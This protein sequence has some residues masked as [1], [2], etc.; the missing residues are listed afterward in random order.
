MNNNN[1]TNNNLS[2]IGSTHI[3]NNKITS[4]FILTT[5]NIL[6]THSSNFTLATS[7]ILQSNS[8][9][10]TNALRYDVNKWIN[11][12]TDELIPNLNVI[13]TYISNSNIGGYIN[14]WTKDSQKLY[15]RINQNGKL[16]IYHD[17][18][19]GR[20]NLNTKWYEVEDILMDYLFNIVIINAGA[21][22][23]GVKFDTIDGQLQTHTAQI[24]TLFDG[25]VLINIELTKHEEL[26]DYLF[27]ELD[28][29]RYTYFNGLPDTTTIVNAM[30]QN[31]QSVSRIN[32]YV[33][34]LISSGV[35][36]GLIGGA[37]G[38]IISNEKE[39]ERL[40]QLYNKI[41]DPK[42][43]I[44][45]LNTTDKNNLINEVNQAFSN[46]AFSYNSNLC[47][48][49]MLNGFINSNMTTAQTIPNI[50]TNSI[51]YN[52]VEISNG[53][54]KK[55]DGGTI[56][57]PIAISAS[58]S[59]SP[60]I[61]YFGNSTG[62]RYILQPST[63]T[64][65]YP[66]SLGIDLNSKS[67]WFS[68]SSNY[69]YDWYIGGSNLLSLNSNNLNFPN[70]NINA[71]NVQISGTDIKTYTQ[72]TIIYNSPNVCKKF[73]FQATCSTSIIMPDALTYY[74]YDIDLRNYTQ[75]KT[76]ANPNTPYRIFTIK[77]FLASAYFEYFSGVPNVLSYEIYMSNESQAG[78]GGG[79]AGIN[80]CA[81][82]SP[83]NYNLNSI[84]PNV[85][86]LLRTGDFNYLSVI[87]RSS[88]A[89]F[90]VIIEDLI[91]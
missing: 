17:Y 1:I 26:I 61:G 72:N 4:N 69:K 77:I 6:E 18:D 20:P 40:H 8:S 34:N 54:L 12:K 2:W 83:Q 67:L 82:G 70:G 21:I 38:L 3:D 81:L 48:L 5:S 9:N 37:I 36:I 56:Y 29:S 46:N 53:F 57:K 85:L 32:S 60:S 66:C 33:Q 31:I 74:K 80:I 76:V 79:Y 24:L 42:S 64:T 52:G 14:F 78:G 35:L 73:G 71:S 30:R 27:T 10:F 84:L 15:T 49:G 89:L 11:E 59:G 41:N 25:I 19:I 63:T 90:N 43:E 50:S 47:N 68:A 23:T 44:R 75:T 16:Q 86:S 87:C 55:N 7:N 88:G 28:F 91:Y 13:N 65:D 51:T 45:F 62:E 58:T 39:N 22:A